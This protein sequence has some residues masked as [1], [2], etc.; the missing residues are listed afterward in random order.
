MI[1]LHNTYIFSGRTTTILSRMNTILL[2]TMFVPYGMKDIP[3]RMMSILC[4][5]MVIPR[6]MESIHSKKSE[7]ISFSIK[8]CFGVNPLSDLKSLMKCDWSKYPL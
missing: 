5:I 4:G 2:R 7:Q 1:I 3:L 6:G 8:Y